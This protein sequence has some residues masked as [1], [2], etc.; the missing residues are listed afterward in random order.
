M[1]SFSLLFV[2]IITAL[3]GFAQTNEA[4]D[5]F[6]FLNQKHN[7]VVRQNLQ[8]TQ[9]SVHS[10]DFFQVEQMRQNLIQN[11]RKARLAVK[12]KIAFEGGLDMR[13]ELVRVL[14][15]YFESFNHDFDEVA[16][17]KKKSKDSYEALEAY[18]KAED[19]LEAKLEAAAN[20]FLAAQKVYASNHHIQL[21]AAEE[22]EVI[23]EINAVNEYIRVLY[24][25]EFRVSK[26]NAYFF[27]ALDK[28][29]AETMEKMRLNLLKV[30]SEELKSL[31]EIPAYKEDSRFLEA[32]RRLIHFYLDLAENGYVDMVGITNKSKEVGLN[33]KDVDAFNKVINDYNDNSV[34]FINDFNE[35]MNFLL[36][37]NVPRPDAETKRL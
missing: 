15:I 18:F 32:T 8:F 13:N 5:Y 23:K 12:K 36:R 16:V 14:D 9:Y 27:D 30:A 26:A 35:T 11:I 24:M 7:D 2:F 17:L 25:K 22:N 6:D 37:N 34:K 1:K 28:D 3:G 29:D 10:D 20:D 21:G 19:D 33:Q 4:V 31:E